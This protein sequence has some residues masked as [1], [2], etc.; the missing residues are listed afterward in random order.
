M[1]KLVEQ[2]QNPAVIAEQ[3]QKNQ[4]ESNPWLD[5]AN[6]ELQRRIVGKL[7]KFRAGHWSAGEA[8]DYVPIG[9]RMVVEA[10]NVYTGWVLWQDAK[11]VEHLMSSIAEGIKP[12]AR[13]SLSF[14]DEVN[15]CPL[16]VTIEEGAE[17][18][19][20]W[21]F[22]VYM[23][24]MDEDGQ[25]YT[26]ASSSRGGRQAAAKVYEAY[27]LRV[28]MHPDLFPIVKLSGGSTEQGEVRA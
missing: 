22:S 27:G 10:E 2:I 5:A 1:N 6:A 7:L 20:P 28:R 18:R 21:Q 23:V 9:T 16:K 11:P 14:W 13:S 3:S 17:P 24:T 26:F 4:R 12:P 19:D 15:Q 25:L 8:G